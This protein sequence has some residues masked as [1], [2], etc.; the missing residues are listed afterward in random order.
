MAT[1]D[2]NH[3]LDAARAPEIYQR[4]ECRADRAPRVQ[5]IVHEDHAAVID[6]ERDLCSFYL[7]LLAAATEIVAVQG[8]IDDA[9][10]YVRMLDL[11]DL[12]L[13]ALGDVDATR[14]NADERQL[15]RALVA[16]EDLVRNPGERPIDGLCVHHDAFVARHV[17][18]KKLP[19]GRGSLTPSV[20]FWGPA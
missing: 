7:G 6:V 8:D 19:R 14:T 13:Q 11:A 3:E 4:V 18:K 2:Q 1:I 16:L 10:R 17:G 12:R 5:H 15:V 9:G 20:V